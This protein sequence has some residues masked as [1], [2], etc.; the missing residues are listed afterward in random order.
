MILHI[1]VSSIY[2][3]CGVIFFPYYWYCFMGKIFFI[4]I[5]CH[6]WNCEI[7]LKW[8]H[9]FSGYEA[10]SIELPLRNFSHRHYGIITSSSISSKSTPTHFKYAATMYEHPD[11]KLCL[12]PNAHS[13]PLQKNTTPNPEK[14]T[15][16][17]R[18][19]FDIDQTK[20]KYYSISALREWLITTNI[21][22]KKYNNI[23]HSNNQKYPHTSN[24]INM[25]LTISLT[26]K[27]IK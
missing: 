16:D 2:G 14:N 1:L 9:Y 27:Q 15:N 21:I 7:F 10:T 13:S 25:F 22:I 11:K 20:F 6:W 24:T 26:R 12:L 23:I 18:K 8:F 5:Y 19:W 3:F 4:N 17:H